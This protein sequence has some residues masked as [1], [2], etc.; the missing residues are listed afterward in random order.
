MGAR[1]GAKNQKL[2]KS[3]SEASAEEHPKTKTLGRR[4]VCLSQRKVTSRMMSKV[5]IR[6]ESGR[7]AVYFGSWWA[8]RESNPDLSLRTLPCCSVTL[9]TH[10]ELAPG[11]AEPGFRFSV[12]PV[13][14]ES[15][16]CFRQR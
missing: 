5:E 7:I 10:L 8:G 12:N 15:S 4:G 6:N 1:R 2:C 3:R 14:T 16:S 9:P 13:R 11:I